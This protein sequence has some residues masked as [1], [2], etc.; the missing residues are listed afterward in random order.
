MNYKVHVVF[1]KDEQG[2]YVHC[3]HLPGCY[4]QG[5]SLEEAQINMRQAL[6]LYSERLTEKEKRIL[7]NKETMVTTMELRVA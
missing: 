3:P 5:R 7:L 6:D 2:Y 4:S 1:T